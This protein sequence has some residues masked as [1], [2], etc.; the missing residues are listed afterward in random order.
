MTS[1]DCS[2]LNFMFMFVEELHVVVSSNLKLAEFSN[3]SRLAASSV[4]SAIKPASQFESN[5]LF[6]SEF[7]KIRFQ[8]HAHSVQ[9]QVDFGKAKIMVSF[10]ILHQQLHFGLSW[11]P[12]PLQPNN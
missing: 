3:K 12:D 4:H 8:Q 1:N 10:C 11:N 7:P 6:I 9:L 5:G 2:L